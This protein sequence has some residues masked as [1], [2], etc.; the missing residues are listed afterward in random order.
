MSDQIKTILADDVSLRAVTREFTDETDVIALDAVS[1]SVVKSRVEHLT[2]GPGAAVVP[3][4][5]SRLAGQGMATSTTNDLASAAEVISWVAG[6]SV[7]GESRLF[8]FGMLTCS[9]QSPFELRGARQPYVI[10]AN[11][12]AS[13]LADAT[14]GMAAVSTDGARLGE[15]VEI[16]IDPSAKRASI[17]VEYRRLARRL[18]RIDGE[19][20]DLVHEGRVILSIDQ[21]AFR[22]LPDL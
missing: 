3:K 10:D 18:K 21:H 20:V 5:G 8:E 16:E 2:Q 6:G 9:A 12:P 14:P 15:V 13:V 19:L 17:V 4:D 7:F 11:D 22:A 1:A